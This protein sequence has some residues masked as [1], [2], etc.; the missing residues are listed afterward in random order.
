MK[1]KKETKW[2][3]LIALVVIGVFANSLNGKFVYDDRRQI[4]GNTLIQTPSL[5]GKALVSDVWAF[6]GDGSASTSNYWRPNFTA[7]CILNYYAFGLDPAD[8][9][10]AN[11]FLHLLVCLFAFLL[12][13]RWGISVFT[14]L[15]ITLIFAVHP[16]HTESVAWISG[17]PD[18]LFGLFFLA[19]LTFA[20]NA[21]NSIKSE[22]KYSLLL[23]VLFYLLALGAKEV[24]FLCFPVYYLIFSRPRDE[25]DKTKNKVPFIWTALF[26]FTAIGYFLAR[27]AVLG[28]VSRPG[29]SAAGLLS[30]I[31]SAPSVF[32]F[33]LRQIIFP[34]WVGINYPLRPVEEIGIL[35]FFVPLVI[36]IVVIAGLGFLAKRSFIQKIGLAL[37]LLPLIPAFNLVAFPPDQIVHDR[38]LYL[39]LLGFLMIVIPFLQELFEKMFA[40]KGDRVLLV[41]SVLICIPLAVQTFLYNRVWMDEISLWQHA[42][43]IDPGSAS[44]WSSLG[45]ELAEQGQ[46]LEAINAYNTSLSIR[47]VPIAYVGRGQNLIKAG[48]TD[49]AIGDLETVIRTGSDKI[50]LY[51]LY[52]AYEALAV[53]YQQK[54]DLDKAAGVVLEARNRL[55]I[56]RAALTE[57]LAVVLYQQNKKPEALRELESMKTQARIELLPASKAIF[58]RLGMLYAEVG[59]K[60][61]ARANLT[62]YLNLTAS[63][64]DKETPANRKQADSLLRQLK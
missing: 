57:K 19:S 34:Y 45:S 35:N 8:W 64:Q 4:A 37:F 58:L 3:I 1:L 21:A 14:A 32:V 46:T 43:T 29:E 50:D 9:H 55:P 42:V 13:R 38:Y 16:I 27:W 61:D 15:S 41:F 36:S 18:L 17:S 39:P 10:K 40:G 51:T 56:Y 22:S 12:L 30:A 6:K 25:G 11:L 54:N 2:L 44:S 49:E 53:A 28:Q 59:R 47:P 20:Q 52:Q 31:L 7:W 5:F 23:A 63:A 33:Y 60:D 62:E 26:A 24:A 48:R